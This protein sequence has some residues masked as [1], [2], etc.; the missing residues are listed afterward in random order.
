LLFL[1]VPN[2]FQ[3]FP[4]GTDVQSSLGVN[5]SSLATLPTQVLNLPPYGNWTNE[6]WNV[7]FHGNVYKQPN[8]SN[9]TLNRLA[10]VFLVGT[11]IN[12]LNETEQDEARNVTAEIFVVQQGNQTVQI[13]IEAAP[14][15]GSSPQSG[16]SGVITPP[17]GNQSFIL[18]YP[19]S[20]EGDFDVF[21]PIANASGGL[22]AGNE[23][24]Q[25]QRLNVYAHGA[26][27][28]NAT[29]YLVP[30]TGFTVVSDIDDILR[31]TQIYIPA[32][33]LNNS[34]AKPY[35]PWLN[36]PDIYANWS[37]SIPTMHF[38]YLTTTPGKLSSKQHWVS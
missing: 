4:T 17:G 22:L 33:G 21:V 2:F 16:G 32:A 27:L 5:D 37:K 28:G 29:A 31:I 12:Q 10:N 6:G 36:M 13:D 30:P 7:R 15:Q 14:S 23:T 24:D 38:H 9:D 25:L 19:T 35:V 8:V 34:F 26:T 1:G 11:D 3:G 18:P 20:P